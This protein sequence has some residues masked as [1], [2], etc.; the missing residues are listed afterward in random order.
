MVALIPLVQIDAILS[1]I[2]LL[3]IVATLAIKRD[4]KDFLFIGFG[5]VG[6]FL[7]EWF[8]ISTGVETFYRQSLFGIMPL[9]LPVLWAYA[10]LVMRRVM[11]I[12]EKL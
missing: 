6:L 4:K 10:F 2:Y 1:G 7:S 12:L 11:I 9:W 3:F 8:F 5:F